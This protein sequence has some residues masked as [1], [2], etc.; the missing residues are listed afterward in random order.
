MERTWNEDERRF[1][2]ADYYGRSKL[3][4]VGI[5]SDG[6]VESIDEAVKEDRKPDGFAHYLDCGGA[7]RFVGYGAVHR[8]KSN[9]APDY[10]RSLFIVVGETV[11]RDSDEP[12][13]R[14]R[15]GLFTRTF[16]AGS[17]ALKSQRIEYRWPMYR[18]LA[19]R[20]LGDPAWFESQDFVWELMGMIKFY[21]KAWLGR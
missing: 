1:L 7:S 4:W 18:E 3:W 19:S 20:L 13:L 9:D 5:G 16:L 21:R 15:Q 8:I 11:Y 6:R 12:R 17:A 2:M 10:A 14:L